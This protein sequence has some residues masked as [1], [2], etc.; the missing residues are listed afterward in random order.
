M[1]PERQQK[2]ICYSRDIDKKLCIAVYV[3]LCRLAGRDDIKFTYG[4]NGKP[5]EENGQFFFSLSHSGQFAAAAL[6]DRP[7]GI[8]IEVIRPVKQAVIKRVCT[9]NELAM[10]SDDDNAS[11]FKIWTFKEAFFKKNGTGLGAGLKSVD[12]SDYADSLTC[13]ITDSY[14]LTI[15]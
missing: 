6:S 13:E 7:I 12:I 5:E 14:V 4:E 11:F 15:I 9:K 8:D 2:C 1:P 10:I 3:L